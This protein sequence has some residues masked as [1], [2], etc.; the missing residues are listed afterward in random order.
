MFVSLVD[1]DVLAR[2]ADDGADLDFVV[3]SFAASNFGQEDGSLGTS[4][5]RP[6]L[7]EETS[8]GQRL[9]VRLGDEPRD[10]TLLKSNLL[11]WYCGYNLSLACGRILGRHPSNLVDILAPEW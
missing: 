8:T 4:Q 5:G 6:G 11:T 9:S 7:V 2:L 10:S 3:A 1:R